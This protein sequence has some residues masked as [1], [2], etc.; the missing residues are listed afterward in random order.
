M[1]LFKNDWDKYPNAIVHDTT[2]NKTFLDIAGKLKMMGV[3]NHL[4][5][6]ALH[7]PDLKDVNPHDPDLTAEEIIQIVIECKENPWYYFREVAMVPGIAGKDSKMFRADR[8]VVSSYWLFFNHITFIN[9]QIRQTGKTTRLATLAR[10]LLNVRCSNTL[11]NLLTKDEKLRSETINTIKELEDVLPYYLHLTTNK[12]SK[13]AELLTVKKRGNRIRTHLPNLSPVAAYKVMRGFTSPIIF[14]DEIAFL[15]NID[16]TL[17]SALPSANAARD[18]ARERGEPYGTVMITTAGRKDEKSG[19]YVYDLIQ[20]SAVWSEKFF[21]CKDLED[22]E[23]TIRNNSPSRKARI[24]MAYNHRQLGYTDDWLR[25]V[26]EETNLTGDD[27]R[28]ELFNEWT[29]GA[30]TSPIPGRDLL[31]IKNSLREPLYTDISHIGGYITRWYLDENEIKTI[32]RQT[33]LVMGL[34]TSDAIGIDDIAMCIRRLDTGGVVA[35]AN[36]NKT[37]IIAF[38]EWL[39]EWFVRYENFTLILERRSSATAIVDF[40]IRLLVA[41]KI[42]PFKRIFNWIVQDA[43]ANSKLFDKINQIPHGADESYYGPYRKYFGFATSGSG[44]TSRNLLYGPILND[45]IKYT[46]DLVHDSVLIQQLTGL[47]IKNGR[48]DHTSGNHDDMVMAWLLSWWF[49][50]HGKNIDYYGINTRSIMTKN[51][52]LMNTEDIEERARLIEQKKLKEELDKLI[53]KLKE[54][55]DIYM[56]DIL[57]KK[58]KNIVHRLYQTGIA[59]DTINLDDMLERIKLHKKRQRRFNVGFYM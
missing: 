30:N 31:R 27:L 50:T 34:D 51:T 29:D 43:D 13:G 10:Y 32:D 14:I 17:A 6:L 44:E 42:N 25:R 11:I 8:S 54:E 58:I 52:A 24:H 26:I 16:I 23:E 19:K 41:N 37:S 1:I 28:R 5:P 55:K 33:H 57:E 36:I 22:L 12:D 53:D 38:S 49:I 21:D 4:F 7:N 15:P 2:R 39:A 45:S 47:T 56:S 40:L 3:E 35:A 9:V 18:E 46:A 20:K 59:Q 48:I